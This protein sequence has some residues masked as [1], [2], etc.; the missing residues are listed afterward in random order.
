M[1]PSLWRCTLGTSKQA[2]GLT[3]MNSV[4]ISLCLR[5]LNGARSTRWATGDAPHIHKFASKGLI[6]IMKLWKEVELH[7][8]T[9]GGKNPRTAFTHRSRRR[10]EGQRCQGENR[11]LK[12]KTKKHPA[13]RI[14]ARWEFG[15]SP[16]ITEGDKNWEEWVG[17]TMCQTSRETAH[18][19]NLHKCMQLSLMR[20]QHALLY[21]PLG[22][23][24]IL[25]KHLAGFV[26]CKSVGE[27]QM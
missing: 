16:K 7:I 23:V 10:R 3:K 18:F 2:G 6:S 27:R 17:K 1:C 25:Q 9:G 4:N 26:R 20:P 15:R 21:S 11:D 12:K 13:T 5:F 22:Y 8:N 19:C 14:L 24:V